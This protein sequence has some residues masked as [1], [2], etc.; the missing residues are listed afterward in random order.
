MVIDSLF[1]E[2]VGGYAHCEHGRMDWTHCP[3]CL[4]EEGK[5]KVERN[6]DPKI[7]TAVKWAIAHCYTT[8]TEFTPAD[9]LDLCDERGI[10]MHDNR[11]LGSL[12][13]AA[14]RADK[15]QMKWCNHCDTPVQRR[16]HRPD[17]HLRFIQV[18]EPM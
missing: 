4:A 11:L 7:R 14:A 16:S 1:S 2:A 15:I 8:M 10:V 18:W 9:V 17:Q 3:G 12:M 6:S 13:T 5:T